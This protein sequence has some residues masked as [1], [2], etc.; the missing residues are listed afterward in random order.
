MYHAE[1]SLNRSG[2]ET[3]VAHVAV[4]VDDVVDFC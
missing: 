4:V 3:V 1:H 2:S